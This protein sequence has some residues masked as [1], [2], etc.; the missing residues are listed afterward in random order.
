MQTVLSAVAS[1]EFNPDETRSGY[2]K[3]SDG[4]RVP[5][6]S[7]EVEL[8]D[9]SSE[10]SL[11]EEEDEQEEEEAAVDAV[12]GE[13]QGNE[14]QNSLP[15]AAVYFRHTISRCIHVQMLDEEGAD[16]C[17]GRKASSAYV[18]LAKKPAFLHPLCSTCER[19]AAR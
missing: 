19:I 7:R 6:S 12:A 11:D 10:S 14:P 17:C 5:A 13:W 8:D 18:R 9:S 16:F 1:G 4:Q 15:L 3:R 2:F